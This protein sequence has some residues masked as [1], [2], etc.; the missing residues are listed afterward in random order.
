MVVDVDVVQVL[1]NGVHG[2]ELD[3]PVEL[4]HVLVPE[5]EPLDDDPR[6]GIDTTAWRGFP[7]ARPANFRIAPPRMSVW[8]TSP[9]STAPA[10]TGSTPVRRTR[11]PPRA[12]MTSAILMELEPT[13]TA[14]QLRAR[15][16]G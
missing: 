14:N 5:P 10:G 8:R 15:R 3:D 11:A 2:F 1:G 9:F 4:L 16:K 7:R 13:S 6:P 12:S